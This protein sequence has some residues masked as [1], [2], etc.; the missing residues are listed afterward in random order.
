[1]ICGEEFQYWYQAAAGSGGRDLAIS[2]E[3][4]Y[5]GKVTCEVGELA[6]IFGSSRTS[7]VVHD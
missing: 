5:D 6:A 7:A 4:H 3:L 2:I 1:M